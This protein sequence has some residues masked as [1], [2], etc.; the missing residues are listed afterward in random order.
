MCD[1]PLRGNA[2]LCPA[3]RRDSD[4]AKDRLRLGRGYRHRDPDALSRVEARHRAAMVEKYAATV[5][6]GERLFE[7]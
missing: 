7:E 2:K 1:V 5:A 3:C 6:K 4:R